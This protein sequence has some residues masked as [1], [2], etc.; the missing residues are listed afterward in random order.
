M[1]VNTG[2]TV[3]R[4]ISFN[5]DDNGNVLRTIPINSINGIGLPYDEVDL[6]AFMDAIKG[7]LP[8]H[9][10]C[11]ITIGG[12]FDTTAVAAVGSLSGS[13]SV[14]Y[15]LPGP[16]SVPLALDVRIGINH[17]W[18]SGEPTFGITGAATAGFICLDYQYAGGGLYAAKFG[19][20]AGSTAPEWNTTAHA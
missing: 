3:D 20:F 6:T 11:V 10:S 18:E 13:H 14:L 16:R 5:V 4:W 9:P 8:A 17:A 2:R 12:P 1:T 15:N 19:V 7:V